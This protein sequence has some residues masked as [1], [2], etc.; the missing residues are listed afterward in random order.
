[1]GGVPR[2]HDPGMSM[3]FP[4]KNHPFRGYPH[5]LGNPMDPSQH[6]AIDVSGGQRLGARLRG[7]AGG[8]L[9]SR[10]MG[11]GFF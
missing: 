2:K 8:V 7:D 5:D 3:D 9:G 11:I 6:H 4:S 1:M 10:N